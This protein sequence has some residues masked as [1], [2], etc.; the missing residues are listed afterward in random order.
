MWVNSSL[1]SWVDSS[2]SGTSPSRSGLGGQVLCP[3]GAM[4]L[5]VTVCW[6]PT[7]KIPARLLPHDS[8]QDRSRQ[9]R[10]VCSLRSEH[11]RCCEI[12]TTDGITFIPFQEGVPVPGPGL[13]PFAVI[14]HLLGPMLFS[15]VQMSVPS[16]VD[17]PSLRSF[18]LFSPLF[19]ERSLCLASSLHCLVTQRVITGKKKRNT[20]SDLNSKNTPTTKTPPF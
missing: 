14:F 16:S 2:V 4:R 5:Q 17:N 9:S 20:A 10:D 3:A 15:G 1:W 11:L 6:P 12:C 18:F 7:G 19:P 8:N 13:T